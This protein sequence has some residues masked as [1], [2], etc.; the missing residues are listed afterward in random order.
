MLLRKGAGTKPVSSLSISPPR[1]V[2]D[3]TPIW[4][5]SKAEPCPETDVKRR[6]I[7]LMNNLRQGERPSFR[8]GFSGRCD[9]DSP[10]KAKSCS[11]HRQNVQESANASRIAFRMKVFRL[12]H[13]EREALCP[14]CIP[15]VRPDTRC[16]QGNSLAYEYGSRSMDRLTGTNLKSTACGFRLAQKQ[17]VQYSVKKTAIVQP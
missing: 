5:H 8:V 3:W 4:G 13:P 9:P 6:V 11:V 14:R 15:T 10:G 16:C 7:F 17:Y 2:P 12:K 1:I